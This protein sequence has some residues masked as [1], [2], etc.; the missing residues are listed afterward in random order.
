MIGIE[1]I[2]PHLY[3][4]DRITAGF[5]VRTGG[6]SSAPFDTLNLGGTTRDNPDDVRRNRYI[7]YDSL[8]IDESCAALMKQVHG[9]TV[10]V[11]SAGGR[12]MN[13]DGLLTATT[14]LLLGVLTADCVPLLLYDP[15]HHVAG[16]V[17]CGWRPIVGGIA[18]ESVERMKKL[19]GTRPETL[20]AVMGPA[21]G[22][23]CYEIGTD[24]AQKLRQSSV[25]VRDG[26]TFGDL[27]SELS[28]RLRDIGLRDEHIEVLPECTVCD[29]RFFSHRRDHGMTGRMMGFVVLRT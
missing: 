3:P 20:L 19:W 28:V 22:A 6:V 25:I 9:S 5:T 18:E 4:V 8:D 29:N 14:G 24:V 21:I 10:E 26:K 13:T 15:E 16:A 1:V 11:V 23:C 27:K 17:H 12:Y 7:L 2:T